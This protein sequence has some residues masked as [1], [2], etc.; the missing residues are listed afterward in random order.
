MARGVKASGLNK[1]VGH[2]LEGSES[3]AAC[4]DA[5]LL[6]ILLFIIAILTTI[7]SN[8]A[9]AAILTP[10]LLDMVKYIC[11]AAIIYAV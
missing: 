2:I 3:L 8:T 4:P 11:S 5:L 7:A 10:I 6:L 1:W 9:C